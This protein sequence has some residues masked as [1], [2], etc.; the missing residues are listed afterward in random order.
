M[1][2]APLR[3]PVGDSSDRSNLGIGNFGPAHGFAETGKIRESFRHADLLPDSAEVESDA[4]GE[5]VSAGT[6]PLVP[7]AT[8]LIE[9]TGEAE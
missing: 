1:L 8:S 4:P 2:R 9:L 5:P 7:P 6:S 3:S